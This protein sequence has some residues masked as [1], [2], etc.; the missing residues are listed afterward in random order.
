MPLPEGHIFRFVNRYQNVNT[1]IAQRS[2]R[3]TRRGRCWPAPPM[4]WAL[5]LGS[6]AAL[7]DG[8]PAAFNGTLNSDYT[9][10]YC[11]PCI[12]L[13]KEI[14]K[15]GCRFEC[16]MLGPRASLICLWTMRMTGLCDELYKLM[17]GGGRRPEQVCAD[18]GFC[19][20]SC[21]CGMCT[22]ESAGQNGRC[23]QESLGSY[24]CDHTGVTTPA[25]LISRSASE[26]PAAS[27]HCFGRKCDF[28]PQNYNCCLECFL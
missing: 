28:S 24:D 19:G 2:T 25:W 1:E 4:L 10:E 27:N 11:Q 20:N 14:H 21:P 17:E 12:E 5:L 9:G 22:M 23:L 3:H 7:S 15:D 13:A 18:L 26:Q 8:L 6:L 16:D